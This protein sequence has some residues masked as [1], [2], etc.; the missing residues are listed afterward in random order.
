M[1]G[2]EPIGRMFENARLENLVIHSGIKR[3]WKY[4]ELF[5]EGRG[6]SLLI[7]GP[8]GA[9]KTRLVTTVLNEIGERW[10]QGSYVYWTMPRFA[11]LRREAWEGGRQDPLEICLEAD[12][13]VVEDIGFEGTLD[14]TGEALY[15]LVDR[16]HRDEKVTILT[17]SLS[18][19][20]LV[21]TYGAWVDQKMLGQYFRCVEISGGQK[22]PPPRRPIN[23]ARR[24]GKSVLE[25]LSGEDTD[26]LS[27][28]ALESLRKLFEKMEK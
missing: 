22:F 15:Y 16:R 6:H 5:L 8:S 19:Q 11:T 2:G 12:V 26:S 13:C 20:E 23:W 3:A 1:L 21:E 18:P 28:K 24:L 9:G 17:T 10:P 25:K 7:W 14:W 27:P 4:L